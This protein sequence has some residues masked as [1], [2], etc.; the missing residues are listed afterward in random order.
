MKMM[1][2]SIQQL[3][4]RNGCTCICVYVC[5]YVY[6][7]FFLFQLYATCDIEKSWFN[8]WFTGHLNFQIEHQ[9]VLVLKDIQILPLT[10]YYH[11]TGWYVFVSVDVC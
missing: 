8:D 3:E 11:V 1:M 7:R 5:V 10:I 9:Y 4:T 6:N 2:I